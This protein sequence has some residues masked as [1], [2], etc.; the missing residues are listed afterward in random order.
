MIG[1]TFDELTYVSWLLRNH[2]DRCVAEGHPRPPA[3]VEMLAHLSSILSRPEPSIDTGDGVVLDDADMALM[4]TLGDVAGALRV[5]VA[6]VERLVRSGALAA[7]AI[8]R[9]VRVRRDDLESYVA[10]LNPTRGLRGL[11]EQE[12]A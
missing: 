5:S 1:G 3:A 9:S 12:T 2:I 8:G 4:L 6:T 10:G 7:C 11:A